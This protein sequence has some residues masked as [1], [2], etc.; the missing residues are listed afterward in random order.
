MRAFNWYREL[1]IKSDKLRLR[2]HDKDE[3]S[4]YS[5]GTKRRRIPFPLGLG[6]ARRHRPSR[7]L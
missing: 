4:H 7:R 3:L 2:E 1:G 6:R 5:V